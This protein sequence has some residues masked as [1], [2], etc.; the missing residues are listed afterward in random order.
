MFWDHAE[1][2][3]AKRVV[4]YITTS[5]YWKHAIEFNDKHL[6]HKIEK[7]ESYQIVGYRRRSS[8]F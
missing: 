4:T 2:V 1:Y 6:G 8:G 5:G 7:R 3:Q